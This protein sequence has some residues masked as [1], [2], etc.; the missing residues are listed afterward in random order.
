MN[1]NLSDQ[2]VRVV[3]VEDNP[4]QRAALMRVLQSSPQLQVM[5]T[6][7]SAEE[8]EP[9]LIAQAPEV[10]LVDIGLPGRSGIELVRALKPRMPQTEF[11]MLTVIEDPARVF[12]ALSAGASGY[13]LK[14]TP[15][16]DLVAA[17]IDLHQGGAPMSAPMA[18]LVIQSFHQPPPRKM[19][20][21]ELAPREHEVLERLAQGWTYKEISDR[22][23]VSLGTVR[24]YIKRIYTKLHVH[25]RVEAMH[26][27]GRVTGTPPRR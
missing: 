17:V 3:L 18:R 20:E 6:F 26:A 9:A 16:D 25:N 23:N 4:D 11:M 15:P 22:L 24:T 8:A 21:S 12:A 7:A 27:A 10:A 2:P 5:A 1:D 14:Q 13:L 19:P